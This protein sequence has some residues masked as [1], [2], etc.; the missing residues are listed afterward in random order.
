MAKI[1]VT[2]GAGYIGS[3]TAFHLMKKGHQVVVVDNLM[4][5]KRQNVPAGAR[6]HICD[7]RDR[8]T[9]REL[10]RQEQFDAI[11][12]FAALIAV[13][14]SVEIPEAYFS[15][16]VAGSCHLL[17]AAMEAEVR[18]F[19]FSSTAAVYGMPQQLPLTEDHPVAP[20]SP[21][22]ESKAMVERLLYWLSSCKQLRYISLRYFNA[23]GADPESGLG[24]EHE[25]ETHLIPRILQALVS[26]EPLI[27]FGKDY[28]TPDGTCIRDYIHVTDLALAHV[29]A[30]EYLLEGGSSHAL[31]AGTGRGYSVLEVI[32]TVEEVTGKPVPY[33]IGPRRAGDA[34]ILV[35]DPV[36][37]Q[38]LLHW[39][40]QFRE[41]KDIIASAWEFEKRRAGIRM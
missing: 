23:C 8:L 27:V 34:P 6:L 5:G 36:R 22:G 17:E 37:I 29:A 12:H 26:G 10:F 39:E 18:A 1:L 41:L 2:G 21:Y 3:I 19:V 33:K 4:R 15:V 14:E 20:V 32:R 24:E 9:C 25:P 16:N 31:N 11:V 38:K 40:P 28:D 30:V 13:G 7:I 35:A